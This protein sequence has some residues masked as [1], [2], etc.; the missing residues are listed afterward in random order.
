MRSHRSKLL[1][2]LGLLFLV[3]V[4][5]D[6]ARADS[7]DFGNARAAQTSAKKLRLATFCLLNRE[8]RRRGLHRLKVDP[9]LRLAARRHARDMV[10][11]R[12]FGHVSRGGAQL[13]DRIRGAGYMSQASSWLVGENLVW[14]AG[15]FSS[16]L[17]R[18][19]ALM[20]SPPH[21][22]N[23]LRSNF[24]E[25]G[26]WVA[27]RAPVRAAYSSGATYVLN[28]GAVDS[29]PRHRGGPSQGAG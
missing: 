8:R 7:C 29:R 2:A 26:V 21:R 3:A 25:V 10:A 19:R 9:S 22:Q 15:R 4:R 14:G 20:Q 23:M 24:R 28:F 6:P 16:P 27:Q 17:D 1:V 12:Y 13:S 5:V 18:V 11:N